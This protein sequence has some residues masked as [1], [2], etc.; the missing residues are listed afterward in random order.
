MTL[1]VIEVSDVGIVEI[2]NAFPW[3]ESHCGTGSDADVVGE[4]GERSGARFE[5]SVMALKVYF[6]V[7]T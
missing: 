3:S 5:S 1:G 6:F 7:Y 2:A 4:R